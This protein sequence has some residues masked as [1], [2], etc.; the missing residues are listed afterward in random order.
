MNISVVEDIR[1]HVDIWLGGADFRVWVTD[2]AAA[3]SK[4]VVATVESGNMPSNKLSHT[5]LEH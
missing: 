1:D 3:G 5:S 4:S 2:L